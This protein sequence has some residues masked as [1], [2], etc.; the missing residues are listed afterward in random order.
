MAFRYRLR[1]LREIVMKSED[2]E[3]LLGISR[4]T[5]IAKSEPLTIETFRAGVKAM[6]EAMGRYDEPCNIVSP[7]YAEWLEKMGFENEKT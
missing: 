1:A 6:T 2:A 7:A 3:F 4:S 5:G